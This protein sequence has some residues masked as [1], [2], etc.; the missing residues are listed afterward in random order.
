MSLPTDEKAFLKIATIGGT[1]ENVYFEVAQQL[2]AQGYSENDLN[3]IEFVD[4]TGMTKDDIE[5]LGTI[6]GVM[7]FSDIHDN[8][9]NAQ[10]LKNLLGLHPEPSDLKLFALSDKPVTS[11]E[12]EKEEKI[13]QKYIDEEFPNLKNKNVSMF[14]SL[15]NIDTPQAMV[16]YTHGIVETSL[17]SDFNYINSIESR[18]KQK[19]DKLLELVKSSLE[20]KHPYTAGHVERV[21]VFA[22]AIAKEM[23]CTDKE[24][25]DIS[26]AA[27]LHDIGKLIIPDRVLAS[28]EQ[29]E[30]DQKKEMDIHD[31]A[32]AQLLEALTAYD[33]DLA[34]KLSPEV[35]KGIK[36]HHK[37]W[38][39]KHDRKSD[40]IDPIHGEKIGK[41]ATIIAVAD[42]IDAM[43][44]Q[45]AYNNPKH[46]LDTFRDLWSNRE[47]QFEPA[48][49]EAAVMLL[50]KEIAS[51]GY[52]PVKMF[53]VVSN[54]PWWGKFDQ[55]LQSFFN[56][57]A[58]EFQV[59]ESPEPGAFSSLGFRLTEQGYFEF[60][61]KNATPLSHQIRYDSEVKFL[62]KNT[63]KIFGLPEGASA[64]EIEAAAKAQSKDKFIKQD[65]EGNAAIQRSTVRKLEKDN[66]KEFSDESLDN[67]LSE[68][69]NTLSLETEKVADP[70][71]P[72]QVY[73]IKIKREDCQNAITTT[74]SLRM[75]ENQHE[76]DIGSQVNTVEDR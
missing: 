71:I 43:T 23:G 14:L 10:T 48:A 59:N 56:A 41:Y 20:L 44:S 1:K 18:T 21:S 2:L 26:I 52:D 42:C 74:K 17:I 13:I 30:D 39:G 27:K 4:I 7:Y 19:V 73:D 75:R 3:E 62:I 35:L 8:P 9:D 55:G 5:E 66:P 68:K 16:A 37:D 24:I 36:Y 40:K 76:I 29:L 65:L 70:D 49:A 51:L 12:Q 22:E 47:K 38:D 53:S 46:I 63:D 57:N 25:E 6:H 64:E 34:E 69:T 67:K 61:G 11:V 31:K 72:K 33:T 45:R 60:N 58:Q 15:A 28:S 54:N 50:G 32:G